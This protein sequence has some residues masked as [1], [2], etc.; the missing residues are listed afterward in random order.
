MGISSLAFTSA[1]SESSRRHDPDGPSPRC[2]DEGRTPR[3]AV[4]PSS[5]RSADE[6]E[7][8][9]LVLSAKYKMEASN[10]DAHDAQSAV[11]RSPSERVPWP[12]TAHACSPSP[13][14]RPSVPKFAS[15]GRN[16]PA[17]SSGRARDVVCRAELGGGLAG[18]NAHAVS[19]LH[20][21]I[22]AAP[23]TLPTP[24]RRSSRPN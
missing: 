15:P 2:T 23:P 4:S 6:A 21:H 10:V 22:H 11:H 1:F 16:C 17:W 7:M 3:S 13:V 5:P 24:S 12:P 8:Y 19:W 14:S 9:S 18:P 20:L